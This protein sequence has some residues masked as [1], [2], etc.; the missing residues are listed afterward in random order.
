MTR[1]W[2]EFRA[3][4]QREEPTTSDP[5]FELKGRTPLSYA[6]G[7]PQANSCLLGNRYLTRCSG[8]FLIAPSGQG[9]SSAIMQS[10]VCW[11]IAQP[12]FEIVPAFP[13]HIT[14]IQAEDDEGD[15]V[16]QAKVIDWLGLDQ[17]Q[18]DL[19]CQNGWIETLNDKV[20]AKAIK[21]IDE[22]L[23]AKPC[24]L[25]ILNPYT[26]YLGASIM[27]DEA[28]SLFLRAQLQGLLNK[29]HCAA[30][31]VHHTPKINF[32]AKT[33]TWSP[34][35]WMYSGAGAA[36]LTNWAR[37]IIA[38]DPLGTTGI[39]KFIAAKRFRQIGWD[40][41]VNYFRH[42][43][44]PDVLLWNKATAAEIAAATGAAKPKNI[45]VENIVNE[46]PLLDGIS[47]M[48]LRKTL[49]DKGASQRAAKT[50]IDIAIEDHLLRVENV[51]VNEKGGRYKIIFR[52]NGTTAQSP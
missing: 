34:T 1:N 27:D 49:E 35:D 14:L 40:D 24:D 48:R 25:L 42:D 2:Q 44:R 50:A 19:I 33:Q 6:Q 51:K 52:N 30:L 26:A 36:V 21:V 8:M 9:K 38:I 43:Q 5:P 37:A 3:N 11:E 39:F 4:L 28:N 15:L 22:I 47:M 29:H 31:I 18:K 12:C 46:V 20:G 7:C 13:L 32:R 45:A 41:P 16:E 10:M 17:L 23:S